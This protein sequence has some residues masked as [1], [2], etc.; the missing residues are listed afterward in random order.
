[1]TKPYASI[2]LVLTVLE[3]PEVV[4]LLLV[5]AVDVGGVDEGGDLV[6]L[7]PGSEAAVP[8]GGGAGADELHAGLVELG[9]EGVVRGDLNRS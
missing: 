3:Q 6:H 7:V 4:L 9:V 2:I 1:M 5:A 8:L